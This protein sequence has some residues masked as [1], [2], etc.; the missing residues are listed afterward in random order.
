MSNC[1]F[2]LQ[3]GKD[4]SKQFVLQQHSLTSRYK[5]SFLWDVKEP[6]HCSQRVGDVVPGDV[7][8]SLCVY[9]HGWVGKCSEILAA[10]SYSVNPRVN[11]EMMMMMMMMFELFSYETH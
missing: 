2:V 5:P 9:S 6:T 4:I 11:K 10:L 1:V 7:V 3:F 8:W